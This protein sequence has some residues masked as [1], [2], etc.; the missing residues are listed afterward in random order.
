[1]VKVE[2]ELLRKLQLTELEMMVEVDRICRKYKIQYSLDGGT[3]LGAIRHNGFIPW[4]DD[5]DIVML[6]R[7]YEK[8]YKACKKEL[9]T[10]R[11]FLQDYRTDKN[12]L[13]GYA[14]MRR[15]HTVFLREGQE[16]VKCHRGVC[17]DIFLYDNVPDNPLLRRVHLFWCYCI[18]KGQYSEVGKR[19]AE[20][21][22]MRG[23][24]SLISKIP[25]DWWFK[26]IEWIAGIT[27]R[28]KTKLARHMTYP[29]RKEC[30]YG[31]PRECFDEYIEKDFEGI[32]F[33]I[34]KKYDL[35]LRT[36]YGDYMKIP[37][38]EKR[39]VHP[40]SRVVLDGYVQEEA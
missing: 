9:D 25:R 17:I 14:K 4:D 21:L 32:S 30:R 27:N 37:P 23:W 31:L 40:A 3:L 24:Y 12:Y 35:Y 36:L 10:E 38:V 8:F 5:V 16:H 6:R 13:W 20:S 18:R 11:F 33:K 39:K 29:Y 26:Q 1:M 7:E 19:N 28:R 22:F 34:F 15:N 2:G